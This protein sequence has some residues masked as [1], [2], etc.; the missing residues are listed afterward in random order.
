MADFTKD[1]FQSKNQTW[2]T[3]WSLFN[4]IQERYHLERDCAASAE[5]TKL[6]LYWTE[7]DNCLLQ[8]WS[9]RNWLN[10]PFVNMKNFIKKAF[11]ERE[12][13]FT[14]LL[15][16]ARTNTVWWHE[17]CMQGEVLFIKGRPKFKDC[18]HGLPTPLALVMFGGEAI[19]GKMGS[20]DLPRKA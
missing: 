10:P 6:P 20:F 1:R 3:P 9:G 5:N 11:L 12:R 14:I 17:M 7:Q 16:P 13:A 8:E 4:A 18:T 2:E 15:I 19:P